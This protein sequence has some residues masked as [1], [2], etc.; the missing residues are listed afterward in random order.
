MDRQR[1]PFAH[2][3]RSFRTL[4]PDGAVAAQPLLWPRLSL[5]T[6]RCHLSQ[7]ISCPEFWA[8]TRAECPEA[9]PAWCL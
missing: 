6:F 5:P 3:A 7:F 8:N 2:S 9:I 4:I 1:Y